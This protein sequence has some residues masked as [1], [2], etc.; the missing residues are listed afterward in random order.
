MS[1]K[2]RGATK[3]KKATKAAGKSRVWF[4]GKADPRARVAAVL[5][6][7]DPRKR[8]EMETALAMAEAVRVA[9]E[10][11]AREARLDHERGR[12]HPGERLGAG[13]LVELLLRERGRE[14]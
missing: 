5:A 14:P 12:R 1:K 11:G 13:E 3:G 8:R 4:S 2:R 10:D 9:T 6:E 7:T